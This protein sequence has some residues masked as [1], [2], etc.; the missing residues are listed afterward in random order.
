MFGAVGALLVMNARASTLTFSST[1]GGAP[2]NG[3]GITKENFDGSAPSILTL[4]SHAALETGS[5]FNLYAAPYFSGS[6]AA[7][8]GENP[9][10]G[11]DATQYVAVTGSGTATLNFEAP[12]EYLGILWG[13]VD[14]YNKLTFYDASNKVIG[15]ITGE[16]VEPGAWGNQGVGGTYYVNINSTD[17]FVK[18]VV[19]SGFNAFE[20]DDVAY[21][22]T[23]QGTP[24]P[25]PDAQWLL[26]TWLGGL[27]VMA[28]KKHAQRIR[29][30]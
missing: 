5:Q 1:I 30:D 29:R 7:A 18:V 17:P 28:R 13:S 27:G 11:H 21:S 15:Q 3:S 25:L 24:V 20:F 8:F 26:A 4:G 19:N 2:P 16:Q 14:F 6:T 12:E 9:D 23:R 10:T 22:P